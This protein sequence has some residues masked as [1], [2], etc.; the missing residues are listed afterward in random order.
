[1]LMNRN[2]VYTVIF[3][4]VWILSGCIKETY[5][6]NRLS[7]EV[8]ISPGFAFPVASG[9]LTF[10]DILKSNDTVRYESDN[11]V[12]IVIKRDSVVFL[13]LEDYYDFSKLVS[14]KK[15]FELGEIG[16]NDFQ[17]STTLKL[18]DII[19]FFSPSL[20]Q[21]FID[22]DDGQPH[23]FP[24]F[25]ITNIGERSFPVIT[26]FENVL[27]GSGTLQI[28]VTN[29]LTAPLKDIKIRLYS[30]PGHILIGSEKTI[31]G[32][33][34][35]GATGTAVIDLT[36]AA[37]TNS[38]VA[39]IVLTGS[40]GAQNVIIDLDHTV[41]FTVNAFNLKIKAGRAIIKDQ[42][43][44]FDE[45]ADTIDVDLGEDI[46]I[47]NAKI[48]KG[49]LHYRVTSKTNLTGSVSFTL[50]TSKY[51]NNGPLSEL[52]TVNPWQTAEGFIDLSN[53]SVDLSKDL[54]QPY[55]RLP[56][57]NEVKVGS[58]NKMI[59]YSM[60]DSIYV[61]LDVSDAVVD[62][63]KGYF[64]QREEQINPDTIDTELEK[65]LKKISGDFHISKPSIKVNYLNS[66]GIPAMIT[67]NATGKRDNRVQNLNL[68]PF[69]IDYPVFPVRET[70]SVFI[71]D[72]T[73]SSLPDLI[74]LP[75]VEAIF[76]G[77]AKMN[78]DG[79]SGQ[80][81]NYV[82]G[83]SRLLA[84]LEI[85]VP[86]QLW[87]NNLQ[88]ADTVD[89]FLK[90]GENENDKDNP[91][92]PENME[93]FRIQITTSNGFPLGASLK[94]MLYD[95]VTGRILDTIDASDLIKPATVDASGKVVSPVE[96][97]TKIDFDKHFFETSKD[98]DKII[99]VFKLITSGG[100]TKDVK[101]YSDYK[102]TYRVNIN[103]KPKFIFNNR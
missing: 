99:F 87:I 35:P 66:F 65:I 41:V 97:V 23:D 74:S 67:I 40:D 36:G 78:P 46:E 19:Q 55:N 30:N 12:K 43:L 84:S 83:D 70:S 92:R 25:P 94:L 82:F 16:I 50:P 73:N 2:T 11:F 28:S 77:S 57:N 59:N 100:G 58:N 72:G 51:D 13:K 54:A 14:Y 9:D 5:D 17:I 56:V 34:S 22:L 68:A 6:L 64:G 89:N 21:Q 75:P 20:R 61:A 103:A 93:Y 53:I 7:E 76:S 27:F 4:S 24:S 69:R 71:V 38:I 81:N 26:S 88:F 90:S 33:I 37:I 42:T 44:D 47:E 29:N 39:A 79:P 48:K 86:L 63:V 95:T 32:P 80:R 52:I 45:D 96:T 102:I 8:Q 49:T 31:A 98:A 15:G 18:N 101:F 60:L 85:E 1:M 10:A 91:F 3:L 62:F